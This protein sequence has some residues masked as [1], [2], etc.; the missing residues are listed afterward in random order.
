MPD[1][2]TITYTLIAF[3]DLEADPYW[4]QLVAEYAQECHVAGM[5][6]CEYQGDIYRGLETTGRVR[7][8]AAYI[9]GVLVGFCNLLVSVLPHYGKVVGTAE[10]IFVGKAHRGTGA[11][12]GL[13]RMAEQVCAEA[14]AVGML[15]SS[16][17]NG[18][19]E[20]LMPTL[21]Y[22]HSNTVFFKALA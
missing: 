11:G 2:P 5:P 8:I 22:T 10:S 4:H 3:N 9:D 16:P 21:G 1:E 12:L 17:A 15:M 7:L 19:M 6:P 18:S 14:G 13:I 20:R